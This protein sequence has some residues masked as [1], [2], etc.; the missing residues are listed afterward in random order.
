MKKR[1]TCRLILAIVLV[2]ILSGCVSHIKELR[3]AQREFNQAARL[4]N[5]LRL[6]PLNPD[7]LTIKGQADASY[8][9]TLKTINRL[10]D[11]EKDALVRDNLIGT[12]YTLKALAEWRLKRYSDAMRTVSLVTEKYGKGLF[13]RDRAI[14][15]AIKG[16]IMNDQAYMHM[17]KKDYGYER[18][19]NLLKAS[20]NS[21]KEAIAITPAEHDLILY[22]RLSELAVLKNWKDLRGEPEYRVLRPEGF[23]PGEELKRWCAVAVP[24][25]ERFTKEVKTTGGADAERIRNW[26]AQ[27]L[28]MPQAC[29]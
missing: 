20:I 1:K 6:N 28:S 15:V 22:L 11:S 4:E 8:L 17:I 16:L 29:R 5:Q 14:I 3:E 27:R 25:W 24:V 10:L 18:I 12:A 7:A 26:W 21:I 19:L 23:V 9:L 13:P 2:F